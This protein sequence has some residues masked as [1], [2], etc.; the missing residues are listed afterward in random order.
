MIKNL[1][2]CY[3]VLVEMAKGSISTSDEVMK[4]SRR[5]SNPALQNN[6]I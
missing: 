6:K 5:P 3:G 2:T 4:L 1:S